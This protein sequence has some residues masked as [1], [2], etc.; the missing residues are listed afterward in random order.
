MGWEAAGQPEDD[1]YDQ[2]ALGLDRGS[3]DRG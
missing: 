1:A 2:T 3:F